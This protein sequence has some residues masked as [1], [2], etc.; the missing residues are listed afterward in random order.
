MVND[1]FNIF[2]HLINVFIFSG[3]EATVC[4]KHEKMVEL[5]AF[6]KKENGIR[7]SIFG[8]SFI[9]RYCNG[10]RNFDW[11]M[12]PEIQEAYLRRK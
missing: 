3:F 4:P 11:G 2:Y 5:K 10:L 9:L 7:Y 1:S 12:S 6:A 8:I